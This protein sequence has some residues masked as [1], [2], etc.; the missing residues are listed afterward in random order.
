MLLTNVWPYLALLAH[1]VLAAVNQTGTA[2]VVTPLGTGTS[3]DDSTQILDAYKRCGKGGSIEFTP[4]NYYIGKVMDMIDLRNCDISIYG[5]FIW[6]TN[7]QY[8]LANSISVTYAGR[9]AA[10][11]VGGENIT[12]RGYGKALFDG[13]GQTWYD[14]NRNQGNQNGRPI[15]FTVWRAKNILVDGITWRQPQFWY[16]MIL[17]LEQ[18][19]DTKC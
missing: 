6:S 7:I 1:P 13:N 12:I 9:S 3:A 14:Q 2:C 19:S 17:D 18:N 4:G 15:S 11:R 16:V 5:K 10:W 8:W